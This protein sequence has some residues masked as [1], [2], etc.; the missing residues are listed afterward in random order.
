MLSI[1]NLGVTDIEVLVLSWFFDWFNWSYPKIWIWLPKDSSLF[2]IQYALSVFHKLFLIL[3]FCSVFSLSKQILF[4]FWCQL[5][6]I[7]FEMWALF[8]VIVC[9]INAIVHFIPS[10][11]KLI[12]L[13]VP[14]QP[15]K[16]LS[17]ANTMDFGLLPHWVAVTFHMV[18]SFMLT[19]PFCPT[20]KKRLKML[21]CSC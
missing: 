19:S 16:I 7:H 18:F 21:F 8:H 1:Y 2:T 5:I 12:L 13:L 3:W 20:K 10:S 4:F 15:T 6:E 9:N 17:T 14:I 11:H